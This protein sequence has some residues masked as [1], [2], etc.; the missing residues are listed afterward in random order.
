MPSLK[1]KTKFIL[2]TLPWLLITRKKNA[3]CEK[4]VYNLLGIGGSGDFNY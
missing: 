1:K 3:K 2:F 4:E